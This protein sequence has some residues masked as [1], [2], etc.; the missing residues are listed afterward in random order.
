MKRKRFTEE[1]DHF[2]LKRARGRHEGRRRASGFHC[3]RVRAA[4]ALS[5]NAGRAMPYYADAF[6]GQLGLPRLPHVPETARLPAIH[7][8]LLV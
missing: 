1:Q 3:D 4:S 2:D 5:L 8:A 6:N 7:V